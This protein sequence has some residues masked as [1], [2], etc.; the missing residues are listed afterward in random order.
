MPAVAKVTKDM[1]VDAAF[2]LAR[3]EGAERINARTV[4]ARLGCSTQPIMYHFKTIEE[5]KKAA[6]Q[7]ADVYHSKYLLRLRSDYPMRDIG[8]NYLRFSTE[9]KH[10]FRF[11]FQSNSFS[12][13]SILDLIDDSELQPILAVLC[14]ESDITLEQAKTVFRSVFLCAHGYASMLANNDMVVDAE[15]IAADLDLVLFG[16]LRVL[17]QSDRVNAYVSRL[18]R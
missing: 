14:R 16:T 10:L 18:S 8:E 15:S 12:G 4:A 13:R 1:I 5:L 2:E 11:L 9:E 17:K 6:Y 7:R 3:A